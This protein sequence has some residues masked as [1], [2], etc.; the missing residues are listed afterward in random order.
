MIN[1]YG[2]RAFDDVL[3]EI[4]KSLK[5]YNSIATTTSNTDTANTNP[6]KVRKYS[7]SKNK[8]LTQINQ[9]NQKVVLSYIDKVLTDKE[10]KDTELIH[11]ILHTIDPTNL[12]ISRSNLKLLLKK[13]HKN[14]HNDYDQEY[15]MKLPNLN[16]VLSE[17]F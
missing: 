4:D 1:Y 8:R 9:E 14:T 7:K 11:N 10:K 16:I 2:R 3:S 6:H 13:I 12:D 5:S 17:I 15:T